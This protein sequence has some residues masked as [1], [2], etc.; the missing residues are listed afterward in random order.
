MA[1]VNPKVPSNRNASSYQPAEKINAGPAGGKKVSGK[2]NNGL[3]QDSDNKSEKNS[4]IWQNSNSVDTYHARGTDFPLKKNTDESGM[5]TWGNFKAG[6]YNDLVDDNVNQCGPRHAED[7]G[8]G[9]SGAGT[10]VGR[11]AD[12][13]AANFKIEV[14]DGEGN[15][16]TGEMSAQVMVDFSSGQ[17]SAEGYSSTPVDE[18]E[19]PHV[20][21]GASSGKNR[22]SASG[23]EA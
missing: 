22:F 19:E 1:K 5:A 16:D 14:N 3:G 21:I 12:T 7:D 8:P 4:L 10:P 6:G 15:N 2:P 20:T 23:R 11:N 18:T 13:V 17:I 9:S